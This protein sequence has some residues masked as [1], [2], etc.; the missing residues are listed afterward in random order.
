MIIFDEAICIV[1]CLEGMGLVFTASK[2]I[3]SKH[4]SISI[5]FCNKHKYVGV[6]C[7]QLLLVV[8]IVVVKRHA[9]RQDL[10]FLRLFHREKSP[11]EL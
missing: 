10:D 1:V 6:Q 2:Y 7:T 3:S 4:I 8:Q 9:G 11:Q 5:V